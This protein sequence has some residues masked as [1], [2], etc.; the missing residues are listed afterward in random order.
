MP[1]LI[2]FHK[3]ISFLSIRTL[4]A[5]CTWL[6]LFAQ[7]NSILKSAPWTEFMPSSKFPLIDSNCIVNV[8]GAFHKWHQFYGYLMRTATF[9]FI[10]RYPKHQCEALFRS[11]VFQRQ[12]VENRCSLLS[13]IQCLPLYVQIISPWGIYRLCDEGI[14]SRENSCRILLNEHKLYYSSTL[15]GCYAKK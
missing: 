11:L 7:V 4:T 14:A 1:P 5:V 6:Y 2:V 8:P 3:P 15:W 12:T 13:I 10:I 9:S